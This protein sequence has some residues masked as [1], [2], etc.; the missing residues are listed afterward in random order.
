M[1]KE[2]LFHLIAL[3]DKASDGLTKLRSD[4]GEWFSKEFL[5]ENSY[6]YLIAIV[7]DSTNS[8]ALP[9]VGKNEESDKLNAFVI[10]ISDKPRQIEWGNVL[11]YI[12]IPSNKQ[13]DTLKDSFQVLYHDALYVPSLISFDFNDWINI[14]KGQYSLKLWKKNLD[15]KS[16]S[17]LSELPIQFISDGK[18]I[19]VAGLPTL[20]DNETEKYIK[21]V[22]ALFDR[23]PE[24]SVR[25]WTVIGKELPLEEAYIAVLQLSKLH[26]SI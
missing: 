23:L 16:L 26:K 25:K 14:A 22:N 4:L 19:I 10:D 3:G 9:V 6:R 17:Q 13:Y 20:K 15:D 24:D 18:Y 11:S 7:D 21:V 12:W 1:E 8:S 2:T 5:S